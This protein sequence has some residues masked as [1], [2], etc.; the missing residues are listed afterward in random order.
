MIRAPHTKWAS[1]GLVVVT[2]G[3]IATL[4]MADGIFFADPVTYP[5]N[6]SRLVVVG[7]L[8]GDDDL[9]IV[10]NCRPSDSIGVFLNLGDGTFAPAIG[11]PAGSDPYQ[12]ALGD[13]DGDD[14]PDLVVAQ[15][16]TDAVLVLLNNGDA[17]FAPP[18][19]L[20]VPNQPRSI[21]LGDLEQG[22]RRA[23]TIGRPS[24][25]LQLEADGRLRE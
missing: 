25:R 3:S 21:A 17:T 8:D 18:D 14:D 5:G 9:D 23:D 16:Y 15:R 24:D 2:I 11:Y 13:L 1:R 7:D 22:Q 4:T 19:S 6:Q 10:T 12:L 20:A